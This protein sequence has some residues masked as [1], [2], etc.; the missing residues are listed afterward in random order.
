MVRRI[1]DFLIKVSKTWKAF[2]CNKTDLITIGVRSDATIDIDF[3]FND[4]EENDV[5]WKSNNITIEQAEFLMAELGVIMPRAKLRASTIKDIQV[6][7]EESQVKS[8]YSSPVVKN[9]GNLKNVTEKNMD[10]VNN[11]TS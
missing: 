8:E 1:T 6:K 4:K 3:M 2:M 9:V 11:A 7:S 5:V 10:G